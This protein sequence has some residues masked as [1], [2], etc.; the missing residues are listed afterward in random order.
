VSGYPAFARWLREYRGV[1]A[2]TDPAWLRAYKL[3]FR[4]GYRAGFKDG[5]AEIETRRKEG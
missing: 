1:F 4:A 5:Q 2:E 3:A